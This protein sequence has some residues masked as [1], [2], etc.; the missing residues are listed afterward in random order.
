MISEGKTS[1]KALS[2]T[3]L[4]CLMM[5]STICGSGQEPDDQS[6]EADSKSSETFTVQSAPIKIEVK[7]SGVF[8][9][10]TSRRVKSNTKQVTTLTIEKA[11]PHGSQVAKGEAIIWFE[12]PQVDKQLREAETNAQLAE[13]TR[14]DGLFKKEQAEKLSKLDR[15]AIERTRRDAQQ[16]YDNFVKVD[17]AR[18]KQSAQFSLQLSEASLENAIEELEQLEK[19][20]QEDEL[21]EESEEIVLKRARRSVESAQF[22]LGSAKI[23]Y[24]RTLKQELPRAEETQKD[25]V[26]RQELTYD[27]AIHDFETSQKRQQ[28]EEKKQEIQFQKQRKDLEELRQDRQNLVMKSPLD[29]V[30]Y[31]GPIVFGRVIDIRAQA[32]A[33]LV[34]GTSVT[35]QQILMTVVDPTNLQI[36]L[37]LSE[38]DL[39]RVAIGTVGTLSPTAYENRNLSVKVESLSLV[40]HGPGKYDCVLSVQLGG[41]DP[42]VMPGM[43]GAVTLV[44]YENND[45]LLVPQAAVFE[46]GK[47]VYM[48]LEEGQSEARPVKTGRKIG[49]KIEIREGL[50][51][52]DKICLKKPE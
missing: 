24:E 38:K 50:A 47:I 15:E 9:S 3:M 8:E 5:V 52:G 37:D 39:G 30:V 46:D 41:N 16:E 35:N 6:P 42:P 7:A 28:N 44:V 32:K 2:V 27:K 31:Y 13:L 48:K 45:A 10:R 18:R 1:M 14:R 49:D 34:P 40:P 25:I 12:T 11:V 36:R 26:V 17:L 29:G 22:S 21:T 4:V 51:A 19:M 33:G 43:T 20:Y 23:R